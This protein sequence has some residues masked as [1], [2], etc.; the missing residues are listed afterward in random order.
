MSASP[1]PKPSPEER[2]AAFLQGYRQKREAATDAVLNEFSGNPR[3]L[4]AEICYLRHAFGRIADAVDRVKAG[5]LF[6]LLPYGPH[7]R[8]KGEGND[9]QVDVSLE[10]A[11]LELASLE[12]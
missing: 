2:R 7:G 5:M 4:A 8:P 3:A 10:L 11:S 6:E 1:R 9:V 12:N